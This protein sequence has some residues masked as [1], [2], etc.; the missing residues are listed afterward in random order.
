MKDRWVGGGAVTVEQVL[1]VLQQ[2]GRDPD[3]D[4]LEPFPGGA[5]P[6]VAAARGGR[7]GGD[8]GGEEGLAGVEDL[9]RE[10][11]QVAGE[12][13]LH[14][15]FGAADGGGG[16]HQ[17]RSDRRP[18]L[19]PGAQGVDDRLVEAHHRPESV[20]DE[21]QLI[22]DDQIWGTQRQHRPGLGRRQDPG[23]GMGA[24]APGDV[25][26]EVAVPGALLVDGPEQRRRGRPPRQLRELVDRADDQRRGEPVDLLVRDEHRQTLLGGAAW[27]VGAVPLGVTAEHQDPTTLVVGTQVPP[28]GQR[29][30]TPRARRQL[31]RPTDGVID[32]SGVLDSSAGFVEGIGGDRAPHPQPDPERGDTPPGVPA[33]DAFAAQLLA[34]TDQRRSA[35]KLLR[36]EQPQ[37]VP[38]KDGDTIGAVPGLRPGANHP[39]QPAEPQGERG[40]P[41]VS[42]SLAAAGGEEQQLRL[43][44]DVAVSIRM[45]GI[46]Q[47]GQAQQDERQLERSPAALGRDV[48]A[49]QQLVEH[50]G[51]VRGPGPHHLAAYTLQGHRRVGET[52]RLPG[53]GV[54][55]KQVHGTVQP[56]RHHLRISQRITPGRLI[57]L[58]LGVVEAVPLS[59]Q[60]HAVAHRE[61]AQSPLQVV[62]S[63]LG[64]TEPGHVGH[65]T[66]HARPFPRHGQ[67][68]VGGGEA[69]GP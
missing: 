67:G 60:P 65:Q 31:Q 2:C 38:H 47:P 59:P 5:D 61:G 25:G 63:K 1:G 42:L 34:R 13:L 4:G 19:D 56:V 51:G 26:A 15:I 69:G 54:I 41:Q 57:P 29:G 16:G 44:L 10:D 30:P 49:G 9:R 14:L 53:L 46:G 66:R 39:L 48:E 20:R 55:T 8:H 64:T 22:L 37:R 28:G 36:G 7:A 35:L 45:G 17:H 62:A 43:T 11:R 3:L 50:R 33:G 24:A 32:P 6:A 21:V 12:D 40:Q 58:H 27:A 18:V 68:D 52:E 23:A